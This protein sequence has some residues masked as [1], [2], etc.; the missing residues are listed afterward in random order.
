MFPLWTTRTSEEGLSTRSILL[1]VRHTPVNC[2]TKKRQQQNKI[3]ESGNQCP[4]ERHKNWERA[5]DQPQYLNPENKCLHCAGNHRS[6][7]CPPRHQHQAPP[8][9]NPVGSTGTHSPLFF[10]I[11]KSFTPTTFPAKSVYSWIVNT[12]IDG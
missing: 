3:H 6:R 1:M 10:L 2:P 11:F 4:E 9:T 12:D 7:D 8:A 5:Q